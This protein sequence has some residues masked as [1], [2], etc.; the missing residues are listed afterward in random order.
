MADLP[1][2]GRDVQVARWKRDYQIRNPAADV[3]PGT[4]PDALANAT[5]DALLPIFAK[6]DTLERNQTRDGK[7]GKAVD[8]YLAEIG[9]DPRRG[10]IGSTGAVTVGVQS[11]GQFIDALQE[12]SFNG[13]L[14]ETS[15]RKFVTDGGWIGVRAKSTGTETNQ[16]AGTILT[17]TSAPSGIARTATVKA[18]SDGTGLTGG[19]PAESD[20][21][22]LARAED[23]LQNQ[24]GDSNVAQYRQV[25]KDTP[26]VSVEEA[27][28]YPAIKD[29]GTIGLVFT[30]IPAGPGAT[31]VP[32]ATA[33]AIVT[34][35]LSPGGQQWLDVPLVCTLV[36]VPTD[37]ALQIVWVQGAGWID[38]T[39]WPSFSS[40]LAQ[41]SL[42]LGNAPTALTCDVVNASTAPVAGQ[43][44]AFLDKT[45]DPSGTP[46]FL[47]RRKKI[48]SFTTTVSMGVTYYRLTF[49]GTF[50]AS[51]LTYVP[52][53]G[54]PFCPWSDSLQA[55]APPMV[56]YF[57]TLG[58]GEQVGSF[59]DQGQ[60]QK[61]QPFSPGKWPSSLTTRSLVDIINLPQVED[62]LPY[63]PT[64]PYDCPVGVKG[65]SSKILTL[66]NLLAFP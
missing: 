30:G 34:G 62:A 12:L 15:E 51:D 17:W 56:R 63:S 7:R 19:A 44:I 46:L 54:Q 26:G 40:P 64:L 41:V 58:P 37:Y 13:I 16:I 20:E 32:T 10:A 35:Q 39:P 47:Y 5:T 28:G 48:L 6:A 61:R 36:E 59:F 3:T 2:P 43:S 38:A 65:V 11:A 53:V 23:Y 31:R 55:L 29:A 52:Y 66:G 45:L 27:F 50:N 57:D 60:R 25:I 4:L 21:D 33:I 49:D 9:A 18:Q 42:A 14:Y 24:P 22:A 1:L 8:E